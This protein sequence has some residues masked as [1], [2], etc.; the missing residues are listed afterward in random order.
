[1]NNCYCGKNLPYKECCKPFIF[2]KRLPTTAEDTMRSRYTAYVV[3]EID[4]IYNTHSLKTRNT[5]TKEEIKHWSDSIKWDKLEII[6]TVHG[7]TEDLEGI[8]EFKGYYS[9]KG[10]TLSHHERSIFKKIDNQWF[11][12]TAVSTQKMIKKD[13]KIGRNDQCPCNSGKKYKKCCGKN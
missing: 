7:D 12:E 3:G 1:M 6:E 11:Y 2:G 13:T 9:E 8:V 4:Y 10:K 5:V